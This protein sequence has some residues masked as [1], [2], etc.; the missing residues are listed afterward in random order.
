MMIAH[1]VF[2]ILTIVLL[3]FLN[4]MVGMLIKIRINKTYEKKLIEA[5][6]EL[7]RSEEEQE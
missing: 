7:N 1:V 6:E 4:V 2:M 5:E 3:L